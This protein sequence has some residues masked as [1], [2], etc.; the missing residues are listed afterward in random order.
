[1]LLVFVNFFILFVLCLKLCFPQVLTS[2][3]TLVKSSLLQWLFPPTFWDQALRWMSLCHYPLSLWINW[4]TRCKI[5]QQWWTIHLLRF[6]LFQFFCFLL[7]STP[8]YSTPTYSIEK[9]FRLNVFIPNLPKFSKK[10]CA[11][12]I[13]WTCER[14]STSKAFS[15]NG[16][17]MKVD[18]SNHDKKG[19]Y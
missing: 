10:L 18:G 3:Q 19:I 6:P 4:N 14:S 12:S 2:S 16:L 7:Q 9:C 17:V 15:Y 1:M 11:A 13:N 5:L 8:T